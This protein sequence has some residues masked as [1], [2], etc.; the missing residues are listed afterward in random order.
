MNGKKIR[1]QNRIE[2]LLG[3][4]IRIEGNIHFSG[5]LHVG[6][7]VRGAVVALPGQPGTLIV[8]ELGHIEGEVRAP[9]VIVF[10]VIVG[11]IHAAETL[12]LQASSRLKGDVHYKR[13]DM[14]QGAVVEGHLVHESAPK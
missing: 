11:T 5:V 13:I 3:S 12:E 6:G 8:S 14:R 2:S 9:R 7:N 1:S 4:T 10:G